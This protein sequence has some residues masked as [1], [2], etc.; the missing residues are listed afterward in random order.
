MDKK[1]VFADFDFAF[2]DKITIPFIV[3]SLVQGKDGQYTDFRLS[4]VNDAYASFAGAS[5]SKLIGKAYY[6]D[7]EKSPYTDKRWLKYIEQVLTAGFIDASDYSSRLAKYVHIQ[8]VK[9]V[10]DNLIGIFCSDV[11]DYEKKIE[12]LTAQK[13]IGGNSEFFNLV[14]Y[15]PIVSSLFIVRKDGSGELNVVPKFF[16]KEFCNMVGDTQEHIIQKLHGNGLC[17]VHSDDAEALNQFIIKNYNQE[18][19]TALQIDYRIMSDK[20]GVI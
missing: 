6:T 8:G 14:S 17:C 2:F 3:V 10:N 11:S 4:Y 18:D 13:Q 19:K 7:I 20:R 9:L 15:L 16:S 12:E 1:S 5:K